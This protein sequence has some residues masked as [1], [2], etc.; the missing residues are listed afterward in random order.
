MHLSPQAARD[1]ALRAEAALTGGAMP[2]AHVSSVATSDAPSASDAAA[3]SRAA[4]PSAPAIAMPTVNVRAAD[5]VPK[6]A[7]GGAPPMSQIADNLSKDEAKQVFKDLLTAV[8][9]LRASGPYRVQSARSLEIRLAR[10]SCAEAVAQGIA[11]SCPSPP[12]FLTAAPFAGVSPLYLC[13]VRSTTSP[14]T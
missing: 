6:A 5:E 13:C 2:P 12:A 1:A 9:E 10:F 8:R 14:R 7:P 4:A 3:R 11:R